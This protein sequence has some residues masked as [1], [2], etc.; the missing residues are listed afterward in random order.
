MPSTRIA[1]LLLGTVLLLA[2]CLGGASGYEM[3]A[4]EQQLKH[5][6]LGSLGSV[7]T[8]TID[9]TV[10]V[11]GE[12]RSI[13]GTVDGVVD[14][15]DREARVRIA[16]SGAASVET[17]T[18]IVGDTAYVNARGMWRRM[19]VSDRNVWDRNAR[20]Q[21]QREIFEAAQFELIG[22][23]TVGGK[24]VRVVRIHVPDDRLDDLRRLAGTDNEGVRIS[25]ATYTASIDAETDRLR[26][27]EADMR[28]NADGQT[29]DAAVTMTF[30]DFDEA[31]TIEVPEEATEGAAIPAG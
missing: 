25:E 12:S 5:E 8:Y 24:P 22:N 26:R 18:Y 29:V 31:V 1:A 17:T 2:G 30:D 23:D 4:R 3:S 7:D 19:N 16:L 14:R 21:Q 20:L 9:G 10:S 6:T 11:S 27:M 13:S 28:M 15:P